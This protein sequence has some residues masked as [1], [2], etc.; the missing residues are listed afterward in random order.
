MCV[1]LPVA[2]APRSIEPRM[3]NRRYT[4]AA[5]YKFVHLPDFRAR[6][7]ALL[8]HCLRHGAKGTV[9]LAS[10][11]I[12]GTLAGSRAGVTKIL[13]YLRADPRLADLTHKESCAARCPFHRMRVKLRRELVSLGMPDLAV[14]QRRGRHVEPEEWNTVLASPDT[15]TLDVR[16]HYESDIGSFRNATAPRTTNFREFPE[17]VDR[18][19]D[20]A[21]HPRIAMFCTGGIRCEK[22]SSYLLSRGF[23]EVLQLRG[24]I[25]NYLEKIDRDQSLWQ[26]DC[27]VFDGRVS[28]NHELAEGQYRQCFACRRPLA[29]DAVNSP[30]YQPGVS[31]P[32]CYD[33]LS[34]AQRRRF[35]ERQRQVELAEQR[36]QQHIGASA[37]A[38]AER[39]AS[40]SEDAV[41]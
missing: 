34:P 26:G 8:E 1:F 6:R 12:N 31:C 36:G 32:A 27:F 28:V 4:I 25:L 40:A 7:P 30:K 23:K 10:E 14:E 33:D 39:S 5:F 41:E 37:A 11:G 13:E 9:L 16:N 3:T 15:L 18:H 17:Y 19:L 21:Q 22:A 35:S 2:G 20:P 29:E 24:G 38:G